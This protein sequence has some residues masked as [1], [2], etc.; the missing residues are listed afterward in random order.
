MNCMDFFIFHSQN[1]NASPLL[2]CNY[3]GV[4]MGEERALGESIAGYMGKH[5]FLRKDVYPSFAENVACLHSF[6]ADKLK[7][8]H[9]DALCYNK[10][11]SGSAPEAA[12]KV[13]SMIGE[14]NA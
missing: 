1:L 6:Y 5:A 11:K 9:L 8:I 7:Y 10:C 13:K 12:L 14:K 3:L 4:D 2:L